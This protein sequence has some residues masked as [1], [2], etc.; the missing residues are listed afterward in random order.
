MSFVASKFIGEHPRPFMETAMP[1]FHYYPDVPQNIPRPTWKGTSG[2]G[3]IANP[4]GT[5]ES[6][7][8]YAVGGAALLLTGVAL[9][10]FLGGKK[11]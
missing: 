4:F 10:Y 3:T 5:T 11:R 2:L 8:V 1:Q 9:G 6:T 7:V